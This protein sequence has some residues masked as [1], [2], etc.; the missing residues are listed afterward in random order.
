MNSI[1]RRAAITA[2]RRRGV[3]RLGRLEGGHAGGDR[4]G[5]G[6]GHGAGRER[7]EDQEERDRLDRA[8]ST[9]SAIVGA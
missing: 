9:W 5:A 2:E 4:L 1:A 8:R 3:P 7:P 6:Q